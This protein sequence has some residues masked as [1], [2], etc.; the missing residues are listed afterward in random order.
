[1]LRKLAARRACTGLRRLAQ[2][3]GDP[4]A[5]REHGE[6][7]PRDRDLHCEG[8]LAQT[9]NVSQTH[10]SREDQAALL[11]AS[12]VGWNTLGERE[13]FRATRPGGVVWLTAGQD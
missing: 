7:S 12:S 8:R 4:E 5:E 11:C 9:F 2:P 1:M 6:Q 3:R 10:L 13:R